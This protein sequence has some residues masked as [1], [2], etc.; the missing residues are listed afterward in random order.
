V[1]GCPRVVAATGDGRRVTVCGKPRPCPDHGGRDWL[2]AQDLDT[3]RALVA[4]DVP[5][6]AALVDELLL[7]RDTWITRAMGESK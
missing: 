5:V 7:D 6:P 3:I 2:P 1:T 4:N